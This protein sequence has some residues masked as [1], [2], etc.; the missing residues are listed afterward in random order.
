MQPQGSL[1]SLGSLGSQGSV[2]MGS[3]GSVHPMAT[4]QRPRR[5][6]ARIALLLVAVLGV[7]LITFGVIALRK[8]QS[9]SSGSQDAAS[10]I[11]ATADAGSAASDT[12]PPPVV[13]DAALPDAAQVVEVPVDAGAEPPKKDA[14]G[15]H[16]GEKR[17]GR[18]VVRAFPVLTVYVDNKKIHDTPVDMN[19]PAGKHRLRLVNPEVGKDESLS[20]T[21]EANKTATIDRN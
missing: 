1:G 7:G 4:V 10:A 5:R 11:A 18:L 6:G 9:A 21:I 16:S 20:V 3:M 17:M 2:P 13:N 8:K 15:S 12:P 14:S 19:L